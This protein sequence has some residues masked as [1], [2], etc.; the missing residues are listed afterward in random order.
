MDNQQKLL[1]SQIVCD[2]KDNSPLY[3]TYK[4]VEVAIAIEYVQNSKNGLVAITQ[5]ELCAIS[6]VSA[7]VARIVNRVLVESGRWEI[8]PGAGRRVT[9]YKPLFFDN[10]DMN[11]GSVA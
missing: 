3:P 6:G 4:F 2:I 7:D 9:T 5:P 11:E 1:L 8:V 10:M